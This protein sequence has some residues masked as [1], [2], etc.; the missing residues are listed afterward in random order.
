MSRGQ[1]LDLVSLS[2]VQL[3]MILVEELY[4]WV[5]DCLGDFRISIIFPVPKT[6]LNGKTKCALASRL[7]HHIKIPIE[8]VGR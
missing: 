3:G 5:V 4:H 1:L 8:T 2:L 7:Q 6:R